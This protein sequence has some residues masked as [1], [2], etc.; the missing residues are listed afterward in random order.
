MIIDFGIRDASFFLIPNTI[1][2]V[3]GG[4][5]DF[6]LREIQSINISWGLDFLQDYLYKLQTLFICGT[7]TI[8]KSENRSVHS[9]SSI[10]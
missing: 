3:L 9:S 7:E 6:V 2:Q 4:G 10:T 5:P 1:Y 8:E